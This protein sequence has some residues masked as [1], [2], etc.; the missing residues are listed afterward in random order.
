MLGVMTEPRKKKPGGRPPV[1]PVIKADVPISFRASRALKRQL[2]E[3][4]RR[5]RRSES[6]EM[7]IAIE[8]HLARNGLWPP[9]E[10]AAEAE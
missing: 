10:D 4:A 1:P 5:T 8:E 2:E 9:P 7:V 3:L 6:K